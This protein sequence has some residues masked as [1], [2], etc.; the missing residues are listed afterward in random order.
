V[1]DDKTTG[2]MFAAPSGFRDSPIGAL[3]PGEV[4]LSTFQVRESVMRTETGEVFA[5]LDMLLDRPV[6]L[7]IAWRDAGTPSLLPEAKRCAAVTDPGAVEIYQIGN[8]RGLEL[9]VS[10]RVA[11]GLVVGWAPNGAGPEDV[12]EVF[13]SIVHAVAA[14][15]DA[16][17]A[18][19][20][21]SG[22]TIAIAPD[23]RVVLGR[24]SMSQVPAIGPDELCVAPEVATGD[25]AQHDPFGAAAIDLYGLGCVAF[26]LATGRPPFGG[27]RE[28]LIHQHVHT[29]PPRLSDT[30]A[31][32]PPELSDLVDELLAKH[33]RSRPSSA[34]V[35]R[36]QIDAIVARA[37]AARRGVRVLVLDGNAARGRALASLA[38]RAHPRATVLAADTGADGLA[39]M[40]RDKPDLILIEAGLGGAMNALE[41]CMAASGAGELEGARLA[42]VGD[43]FSESDRAVF[44]QVGVHDV[45]VRDAKLADAIATLVIGAVGQPRPRDGRRRRVTG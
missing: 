21:V 15:H 14:S 9:V 22:Q 32:L 27:D 18:V 35:V 12:L 30:R 44:A 2:R 42:V 4:V 29:P 31:D 25:V 1:P 40:H 3:S 36:D 38:R 19:G 23:L 33:P 20:E 11:G 17:I 16:G 37:W 7:K 28:M 45:V 10:E 6:A 8:H 34:E 26:E 41:F 43:R 13:R 39:R 5:G 24:L